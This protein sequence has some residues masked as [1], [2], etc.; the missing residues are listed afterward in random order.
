MLYAGECGNCNM[1]CKQG[2]VAAAVCIVCRGV[3]QL[4]YV[5]YA[6]SV[7]AAVRQLQ[8]VLYAGD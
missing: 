8:Y 3:W 2:S 5:L 4:Q 7:A 6:G 1:Y